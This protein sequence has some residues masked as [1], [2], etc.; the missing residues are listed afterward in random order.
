MTPFVRQAAETDLVAIGRLRTMVC[1]EYSLLL[2]QIFVSGLDLTPSFDEAQN[3]LWCVAESS[4]QIVG[5]AFGL[6]QLTPPF[7]VF[8]SRTM[9][10]LQEIGVDPAFRSQGIGTSLLDF[11]AAWAQE[12]EAEEIQ[13]NVYSASPRAVAFYR[14][15]GFEI[16]SMRMTRSLE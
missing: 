16:R 7:P 12:R 6:I 3:G 2:P 11:C 14:R 8:R 13:L 1:D 15:H 9:F 10:A 5:F 4:G